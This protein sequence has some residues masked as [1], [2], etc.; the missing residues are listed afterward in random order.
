M[1]RSRKP[2][3]RNKDTVVMLDTVMLTVLI[4]STLQCQ[5]TQRDAFGQDSNILT[6]DQPLK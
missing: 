3:S 4:L 2:F 6:I 5:V 1:S